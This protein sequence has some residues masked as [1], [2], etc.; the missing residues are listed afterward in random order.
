M[1]LEGYKDLLIDAVNALP[2]PTKTYPDIDDLYV[3]RSALQK[4]LRRGDVGRAEQAAQSLLRDP[5]R[6]WRGLAVTVF[7]DFGSAPVELRGQ[8]VTASASKKVR[9]DLGGDALVARALIRQ[10]CEVPRD[11]RVDE[12]YMFASL[13]ERIPPGSEARGKLS[14]DLRMALERARQLIRQCEQLV[15]RRGFKTV[16]ARA[17]DASLTEMYERGLL[18]EDE[19]ALCIQGRKTTQC[20]LPVLHP[21]PRPVKARQGSLLLS[22]TCPTP[23]S[24]DIAG[25]PSYALDGYTRAGRLAL[26]RLYWSNRDL[27][28]LLGGLKSQSTKL[29]AVAA[30][31]FEVE[32]G[33]CTQEISDPLYDELKRVSKARWSGLPVDLIPDALAAMRVAIPHLNQLRQEV[34]EL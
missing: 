16:L 32:G 5:Q 13:L 22:A 31:L 8:V 6:L 24:R 20:L 23:L 19:L 28:E 1:S 17:C 10:L 30:L 33:V 7:E 15:P 2:S 27:Q 9:D 18:D 29:K 4:A 3:A 21:L 25:T 14:R 34:W 12:L 11:R 26:E